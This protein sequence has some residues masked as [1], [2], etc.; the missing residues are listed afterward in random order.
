M[1]SNGMRSIQDQFYLQ[2]TRGKNSER[3]FARMDT[4]I[5]RN[6]FMLY[7]KDSLF[8]KSPEKA[9][10]SIEGYVDIVKEILKFIKGLCENHCEQF[11]LYML[12]QQGNSV[13]HNMVM[14]IV[15]YVKAL[16]AFI[17]LRIKIEKFD[18]DSHKEEHF[19]KMNLAYK[20]ILLSI[21]TL[22]ETIQGP[23]P[24]NQTAIGMS[25]YYKVAADI[26]NLSY[27]FDKNLET[28]LTNFEIGKLKNECIILLLS[29]FEQREKTDTI[30][31][32]MKE[33]I[34]E[35]TLVNNLLF[36]YYTFIK[37]NKGVYTEELL[38]SVFNCLTL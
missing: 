28:P 21:R 23:C 3:L 30:I 11:Q 27:N 4:T 8:G 35:T 7:N 18:S 24:Q 32:R 2:F 33:F 31:T 25:G 10:D 26:L 1:L 16:T 9:S 15:K 12:D 14:I 20:H 36:V 34:Q 17:K 22:T 13:S 6:I 37:E 29:L 38:L 19:K 5:S